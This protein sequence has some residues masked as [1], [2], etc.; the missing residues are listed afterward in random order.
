M[1]LHDVELQE[2]LDHPGFSEISDDHDVDDQDVE[3]HEVEDHDVESHGVPRTSCSPST[4]SRSPSPSRS[5][6]TC[7][8]PRLFSREPFPADLFSPALAHSPAP[9]DPI[10]PAASTRPDEPPVRYWD[11]RNV[12][13]MRI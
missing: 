10:A 5:A 8:R 1:P 4:S 7:P 6:C 11:A 12:L 3:D 2:V 13:P 9:I